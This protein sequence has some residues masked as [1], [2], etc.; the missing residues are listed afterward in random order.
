MRVEHGLFLLL[1]R[2]CAIKTGS[3]FSKAATNGLFLI[4]IYLFILLLTDLA[5]KF[6]VW[7]GFIYMSLVK[8]SC[9]IVY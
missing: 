4:M 7:P 9:E 3:C 2:A 5:N 6:Q 1:Y 8:Q